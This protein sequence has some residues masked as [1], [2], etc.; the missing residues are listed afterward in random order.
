MLAEA[1]ERCPP[2]V[3]LVQADA[4]E[5]PFPDA[6]FDLV[7]GLDLL[8]HLPDTA[9][10]LRELTR[11][12]RVGGRVVFD[13]TNAVPLWVLAYPSYVNWRPKRLART[14]LGSG[15]LPEWR[16]LVRHHRAAD[17]RRALEEA[18]LQLDRRD[19]FGP[20]WSAKWHLWWTRRL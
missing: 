11:V 2:E 13:T 7:L 20:P 10:A 8:A 3:Q 19:R 18:G 9:Q 6:S 17:V 12:A 5:L 15:V 16:T 4:R 14:L 1:R